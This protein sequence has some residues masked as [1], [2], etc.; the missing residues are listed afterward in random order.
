MLGG[1]EIIDF[2]GTFCVIDGGIKAGDEADAGAFAQNA[3]P[4]TL[5]AMAD[6]GEGSDPGDDD[7]WTAHV[8]RECF[9]LCA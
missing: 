9:R 8:R 3:L 4:E 5:A 7:A 2:P 1:L 6:A